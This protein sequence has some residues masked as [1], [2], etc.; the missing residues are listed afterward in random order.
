MRDHLEP[1]DRYER[2]GVHLGT[3]RR[4][5]VITET[6]PVW[7]LQPA[8]DPLACWR[9]LRAVHDRTGLWPFLAGTQLVERLWQQATGEH[10]PAAISRGL[11]MDAGAWLAER[12]AWAD[13]PDPATVRVDPAAAARAAAAEPQVACSVRDTVIGLVQARHGYEVPGLL[14]WIGAVNVDVDPAHHVAVL[15]CWQQR[16]GAELVTLTFDQIELLV[17]RPPQDPAAIARV[18]VEMMG[19]CP[20]LV[21]Q[22]FD[23]VEALAAEMAPRRCWS[24]WWD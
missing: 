9:R 1:L 18:A 2:L 14:S 15:R 13:T 22:G 8:R 23:G 3:L 24:F 5:C 17:A 16:Y 10:D 6:L 21:L 20:D 19:Y 12:A 7:T 4:A 11:A